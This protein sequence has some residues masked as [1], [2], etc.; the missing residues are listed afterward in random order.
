MWTQLKKTRDDIDLFSVLYKL[1]CSVLG[2]AT[3]PG[4]TLRRGWNPG[5][6]PK[7]LGWNA[8]RKERFCSV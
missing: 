6:S 2:L 4:K 1:V 3:Q 8:G 5:K 7:L